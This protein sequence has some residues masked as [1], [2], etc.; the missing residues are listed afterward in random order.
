MN[1][2]MKTYKALSHEGRISFWV[3]SLIVSIGTG[4]FRDTVALMVDF[5]MREAYERGVEAGKEGR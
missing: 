4:T 2:D 5:I 1:M 3:G